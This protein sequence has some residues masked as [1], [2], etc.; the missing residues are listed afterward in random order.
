[1]Y[2]EEQLY[3]IAL[4]ECN[5]I[6]DINFYKLVRIFGSAK[7]AWEHAK[8]EYRKADGIG[9]KT[10]S[11]IGNIT[12]LEFAE[13]ELKFCENN[14]IQIR[15][16]HLNELPRLL[17]E[18][19]D[20]PA[21]LYQKGNFDDGLKTLS[22][23]G[24]RNISPYGKQFIHDFFEE[25]Q[26]NKY[27]SISGLALGVDKEVHEQSLQYSIPTTAVLAHGFHMLYP[28]KNKKL[29]EKIIEN[30]GA[31][32]TEFNSS[33]K[34]DREN[35]IQRN[36]IVAGISP[37]TIVVET[38]FGGGSISTATFANNYNREV[39]ALPGKITDK[40]SQGCNQLIFHNKARAISTLKDLTDSLDFNKPL[41]KIEELFPR[42]EENIQLSENQTV[43]YNSIINHPQITLDDLAQKISL[44]SHKILP[45]ILEL[46]LLGKV[47]SYSGR[48]F[49]AI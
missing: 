3:S 18:C 43:V 27:I 4:R 44:P 32:F 13:S 23:V 2:S 24:T 35:F 41:E 28:A 7:E 47:K 29:S 31:L 20:A 15:L 38:A 9:R 37:A 19:D 8:K 46:E 17:N 6:G 48:Q 12:Y 25:T 36:R 40:Y 49:T 45:V 33:R 30:N 22:L 14:A 26:S 5:L 39:F 34:P 11:D 16:R 1:M 42:S 10:V 21:I